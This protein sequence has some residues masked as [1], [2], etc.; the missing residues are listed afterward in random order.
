MEPKDLMNESLLVAFERFDSLKDH[1]QFLSFLIGISVRI[2]ANNHKKKKTVQLPPLAQHTVAD[3]HALSDEKTDVHFLYQALALLPTDQHEC[4][5]LFEISGFSIKEIMHIQNAS[6]SA[7]KQRL[8][9][10]RKKLTEVLTFES[11]FK[12]T[13]VR[14]ETK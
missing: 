11:E 4:I 9:R 2:L 5:I 7:V 3:H 13:E 10:A 12:T 14:Y 1:T 6:E 8:R